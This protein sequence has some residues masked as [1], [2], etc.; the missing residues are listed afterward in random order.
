MP[1][2][3][4]SR[5]RRKAAATSISTS[6]YHS[7]ASVKSASAPGWNLR[8]HVPSHERAS[9]LGLP[10][11]SRFRR[12]REESSPMRRW[13][14]SSQSCSAA[15]SSG[16]SS[17]RS[18]QRTRHGRSLAPRHRKGLLKKIAR[19]R[20]DGILSHHPTAAP[21]WSRFSPVSETLDRWLRSPSTALAVCRLANASA[22]SCGPRERKPPGPPA[23]TP[24]WASAGQT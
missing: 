9:I 24:C 15:G 23:A 3:A 13:I 2:I 16:A 14:S 17:K 1:S 4:C 22:F 5:A 21:R 18:Q 8:P 12:R 20:H 19:A 7:C 10:P 6:R 11:S